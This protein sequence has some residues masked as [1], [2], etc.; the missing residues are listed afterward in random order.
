MNETC[1]IYLTEQE[2]VALAVALRQAADRYWHLRDQ[3]Q[4]YGDDWT[5]YDRRA[6]TLH[7][8]WERAL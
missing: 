1:A 4:T 7:H 2:R 5:T 3:C 6:R 8:L